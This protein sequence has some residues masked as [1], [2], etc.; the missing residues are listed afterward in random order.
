MKGRKPNFALRFDACAAK[1]IPALAR[2]RESTPLRTGGRFSTSPGSGFTLVELLVAMAVLAVVLTLIYG[3]GTGTFRLARETESQCDIYAMAGT[4]MERILEDLESTWVA[5]GGAAAETA[6]DK[7]PPTPFRG[8]A[9]E[10]DGRPA[11]FLLF[12]T[13]SHLD[14]LPDGDRAGQGEVRYDVT[15]GDEGAGLTLYRTDRPVYGGTP[16]PGSPGWV[17]CDRLSGVRFLFLDAEGREWDHWDS[18]N[19]ENG[20]RPPPMVTVEL[21]FMNPSAP[22]AP[23]RFRSS[24]ALPVAANVYGNAA[25]SK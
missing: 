5:P 22:D 6:G 13:L 14:F 25:E 24:M 4:A 20:R 11:G 3:A 21:V 9:R 8:E 17:L 2:H 15:E 12:R 7:A 19:K 10:L 18:A 1:A 16:S 23:Y